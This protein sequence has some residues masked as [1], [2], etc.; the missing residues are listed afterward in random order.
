MKWTSSKIAN[1]GRSRHQPKALTK[2]NRGF[3]LIELLVV[4][5][6][7]GGIVSGLMYLVVELLTA[8]QKDSSRNQTQ[9]EMQMAMDY[10]AAELRQAVYIYDG[11]CMG[12]TVPAPTA[13]PGA[14]D[15][16][17]DNNLE[18]GEPGYCPGLLNHLPTSLAPVNGNYPIIAFWKQQPIPNSVKTTCATN[19]STAPTGFTSVNEFRGVCIAGHSYALVVYSLNNSNAGGTWDG[20]ARIERYALTEFDSGGDRNVDEGYVSPGGFNHE[21]RSWPYY[22][23]SA[24]SESSSAPTNQQDGTVTGNSAALVDFVDFASPGT[25]TC[26]TGYSFTA[27][28]GTLTTANSFYGCVSN[29]AE[30]GENREV[31]LYLRGNAA[32]RPGIGSNST[33]FLPTLETRVLSRPVISKPPIE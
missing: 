12:S 2:D 18:P 15:T 27:P 17:G 10:M 11:Q 9:Q 14:Q 6:I 16:D 25:E 3:T 28:G 33:A 4:V 30:R 8:D 26:P 1:L 31:I 19:P 23:A 24:D 32:G 21:F 5:V 13:V 22:Q 7:A 29:S 20:K